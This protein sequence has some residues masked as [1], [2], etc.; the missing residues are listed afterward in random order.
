MERVD[1]TL[2]LINSTSG[3]THHLN[4]TAAAVWEAC[5]GSTSVDDL[6]ERMV[7][8]FDV[9]AATARHDV[10]AVLRRF[11]EVGLIERYDDI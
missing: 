2:V 9:D 4:E 3:L 11:Q 8:R 10:A 1:G 7:S 6:V 5:D